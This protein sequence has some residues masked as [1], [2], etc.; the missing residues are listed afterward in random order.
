MPHRSLFEI[1]CTQSH[2]SVGDLGLISAPAAQLARLE[3]LR[4]QASNLERD[5]RAYAPP[6]ELAAQWATWLANFTQWI[7][8]LRSYQPSWTDRLWGSTAD[9]IETYAREL[10]QMRADLARWPGARVT[11]PTPEA[12]A[13]S[14]AGQSAAKTIAISVAAGVLTVGAI[15]LLSRVIGARR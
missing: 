13:T 12:P 10:G 6:V 4:M 5:V 15:A 7:T 1:G 3:S 9:Q 14:T 11:A 8:Q 2:A